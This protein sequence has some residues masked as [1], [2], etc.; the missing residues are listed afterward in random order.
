MADRACFIGVDP[1]TDQT[2][3]CALFPGD[4]TPKHIGIVPNGELLDHA[5][6]I[7]HDLATSWPAGISVNVGVE[8]IACYGMPVGREV[9]ETCVWIGRFI[10]EWPRLAAPVA[11]RRVYRR[12]VKV[13][14][15]DSPR[16]KDGNIRQ[17]IIDRYPKT[18]GG[19]TPQIGTKADPGPLYGMKSHIWAA[20]GVA[21]TARDTWEKLESFSQISEP[22]KK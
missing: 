20:L 14:V 3:I 18:G 16:A 12:E 19:K 11:M 9:F 1:G 8:M 2:G 13:H 22:I 4:D 15:C 5:S 10:T 7:A 6:D 17:A 21:I